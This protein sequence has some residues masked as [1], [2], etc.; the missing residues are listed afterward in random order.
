LRYGVRRGS[1]LL[2]HTPHAHR[3]LSAEGHALPT[4]SVRNG[5][6]LKSYYVATTM[7]VRRGLCCASNNEE[8]KTFEVDHKYPRVE[9][10][11]RTERQWN[12]TCG[13][14][15]VGEMRRV[16]S[17]LHHRC[18]VVLRQAAVKSPSA[19]PPAAA[20]SAGETCSI[21]FSLIL[22]RFFFEFM[23]A[24]TF[25]ALHGDVIRKRRAR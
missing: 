3:C 8:E 22:F 10:Q 2:R 13:V 19:T 1:R 15:G 18:A 12:A 4:R 11:C 17:C 14:A 6:L 20:G 23:I 9:E 21:V 25:S 5:V 16:V 24:A 7:A